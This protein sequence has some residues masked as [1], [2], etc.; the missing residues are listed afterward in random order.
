MR[1]A[2][3]FWEVDVIWA[4]FSSVCR[5]ARDDTLMNISL[6]LCIVQAMADGVNRRRATIQIY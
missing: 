1:R 2:R 3:F 6:Q 4:G 5:Q